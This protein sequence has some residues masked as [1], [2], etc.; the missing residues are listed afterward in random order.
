MKRDN[1]T[2]VP[3][4]R[5]T[6]LHIDSQVNN[7]KRIAHSKN[8]LK[9]EHIQVFFSINLIEENLSMDIETLNIIKLCGYH[10]FFAPPSKQ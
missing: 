2:F 1:S 5:K 8:A 6:S 7:F 9:L 4:P 10:S 3:L